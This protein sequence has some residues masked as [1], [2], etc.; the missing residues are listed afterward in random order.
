MK[1]TSSADSDRAPTVDSQRLVRLSKRV[2]VQR[3]ARLLRRVSQMSP[4]EM[5]QRGGQLLRGHGRAALLP[6]ASFEVERA[7]A[8]IGERFFI[9]GARQNE[10]V[11]WLD[12][13]APGAARRVREQA[14]TLRRGGVEVFGRSIPLFDGID[15]NADPRSGWRWPERPLDEASA[16]AATRSATAASALVGIDVKSV[17]ELNRHQFLATLGCAAWFDRGAGHDDFAAALID[18]WIAQN[19][20]GVGVNWASPLE[21]GL[22]SISWLWAMGFLLAAPMVANERKVRWIRSL[23]Q[24][25]QALKGR[26]SLHTD[27]TNHLIGETTALWMLAAAMPGLPGADRQRERATGV[28]AVEIE[29]QVTADGVS[30]EQSIGYHCF[31]VDMYVQVVALARRLAIALPAVI[32]TRLESML[33]FLS[34]VLGPA[35]DMPQIGDGDDGRALP[36]PAPLSA[37]ERGEALLAVGAHLFDRPEWMPR[38]GESSDLVYWLLGR[39]AA[40]AA[41]A[42]RRE[43]VD[44]GSTVLREGGYCFLDAISETGQSRQLVFDV[45]GLGYLPNAAHEHADALSILARVNGTLVLGDPGTGTYTGSA[46]I[47]DRFRGTAA[48][49]TVTVDDLDQADM[50]DTFKWVNPVRSELIAWNSTDEFDYVAA[51]HGGYRRLR[52]PV[53]HRRDV[54]FVRPDYWT[55]VDRIE[56]SGDHRIV[57]RFHF[58]PGIELTRRDGTTVDAVSRRSGDGVRLVFPDESRER[59][60]VMRIEPSLWSASYGRWDAAR[61]LAVENAGAAP[62]SLPM[63]IVPLE[64]G[65]SRLRM[66]DCAAGEGDAAGQPATGS[67]VCRTTGWWGALWYEDRV[68]IAPVGGRAAGTTVL[69]FERRDE[70]GRIARQ[71]DGATAVPPAR[72]R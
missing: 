31:V 52:R 37:R 32:E 65:E 53:D 10:A 60:G 16:V 38:R 56:G 25:Y 12:I 7:L 50:L 36:F 55:V 41:P 49:N 67:L 44:S 33:D 43:P 1:R 28:L 18:A 42:R 29:R 21:I 46:A 54:L 9:A 68:A 8:D 30:R 66:I 69:T 71:F 47:R 17:W 45:G 20:S 70:S 22:R 63:L 61:C 24:H 11:T 27:R 13:H 57:R 2:S 58:P 14:A 19:R 40:D 59:A 34:R 64:A 4:A 5:V 51:R 72:N 48:H 3:C 39:E 23:A 62:W 35:G 26:L 6:P 15:W